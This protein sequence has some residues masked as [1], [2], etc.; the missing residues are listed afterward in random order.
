MFD[1]AR[2]SEAFLGAH[3]TVKKRDA[4]ILLGLSQ[5]IRRARQPP[6]TDR[7]RAGADFSVKTLAPS[8]STLAQTAPGSTI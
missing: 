4:L 1:S 6:H 3:S 8:A 7:Q 5:P 2:A